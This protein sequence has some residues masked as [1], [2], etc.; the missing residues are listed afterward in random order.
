MRVEEARIRN[1]IEHFLGRCESP[2][3]DIASES[4]KLEYFDLRACQGDMRRIRDVSVV[5]K[6]LMV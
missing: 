5:M 6:K 1:P 4:E 2:F 3:V